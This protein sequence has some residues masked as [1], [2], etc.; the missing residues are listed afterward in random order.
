MGTLYVDTGGNAANS[1]S[2]DTNSAT[3]TG[4][5]ATFVSG[6]TVQLDSGTDLSSVVT[7]GASQ[8]AINIAGATNSNRTIFW[9][10][11]VSG[12]GGATPQ[13][14]LDVAPTGMTTN[15]WR[16]GGQYVFPG[17]AT[18]N[19]IVNALRA[20][21][22]LQFNNTPATRTNSPYVTTA[23]A[24]DTTSGRIT[25][26]GKTGVRPV[27]EMTGNSQAISGGHNNYV[28]SNL[29][30]K[31]SGTFAI[32]T[33]TTGWLVD[34]VLIT[35][36]GGSS[37]QN[38]ITVAN[39]SVV[40]NCEISGVGGTGISA[41]TNGEGVFAF[42]NYIH[43]CGVDGIT[44]VGTGPRSQIIGNVINGCT[45]RGI[46]ASGASTAQNH[47]LG[48][49][50]NTIYGNTLA[51]IEVTDLDTVVVLRNNIVMNTNTADIVKWA[52]GTAELMSSHAYNV[53]YSSSTGVLNGLTTNSTEFT[54]DPSFSNAGSGNFAIGS[55]SPAAGSGFPGTLPISGTST[56]YRDIGAIQRQVTA[57]SVGV[58]GS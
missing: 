49:I 54:T 31:S 32:L 46:Y 4:T 51:G 40:S 24:G 3:L 17:S 34:N 29:E 55:S 8:S 2:T 20:G 44:V 18:A 11:A 13:V 45:G 33:T 16:I 23:V 35:G 25:I 53:F 52:A 36:T 9:I 43:G 47:Y 39:S 38:G 21:D 12:S 58:I 22:I 28:V 10:T 26:R 27:L 19:V 50:S 56:G 48:I 41:S 5:S 57:G 1:G 14:T 6:T 42:G 7:S 30:L 15:T 37:T